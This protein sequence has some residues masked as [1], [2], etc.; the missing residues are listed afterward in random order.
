MLLGLSSGAIDETP[1]M[2]AVVGAAGGDAGVAAAAALSS[3]AEAA[4]RRDESLTTAREAL[5]A[6]VGDAGVVEAAQT[7][8]IFRSLNIAADASGIPLD[9]DWRGFATE[10][11]GALGLDEFRTAANTPGF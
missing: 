2:S 8:A 1:D 3:F 9:E 11:V 7:V 5:R 4:W 10:F 6:A